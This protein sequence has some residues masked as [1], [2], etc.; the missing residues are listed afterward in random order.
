MVRSYKRERSSVESSVEYE[1]ERD[2]MFRVLAEI[3]PVTFNPLNATDYTPS[4]ELQLVEQVLG[5]NADWHK[6]AAQAS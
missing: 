5:K 1:E 4:P 6:P 2:I 3:D